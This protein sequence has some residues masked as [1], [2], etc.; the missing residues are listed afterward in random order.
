MRRSGGE[1]RAVRG[2]RRRPRARADRSPPPRA[3][4]R[5]PR[6][7]P[8]DAAATIGLAATL[9]CLLEVSAEK[10]GNVTPTRRFPDAGF[11][12]F[13]RSALAIGPAVGRAAP[14]RVGRTVYEAVAATRRVTRTNT[15]LGIALLLAP[16]AA[17]WRSRGPGGLRRRLARLLRRLDVA[18]ARWAYRAIR[19]ARPGGLGRSPV[20]DVR[21][22]PAVTLR[23]AMRL[24][25]HRDAIAWE[26]AHDFG[27]TLGVGRR[28]LRRAG[29]R[30]LST[31]DAIVQA[32]LEVLGHRP[33]TLIARKAGARAAAAVQARA[34]RVLR[35]GGLHT[36][37]GRAAVRRLDRDL[38]RGGHR[39]NPGAAA[40]LVTA[41]LF[42]SLL[43][44]SGRS[45][46]TAALR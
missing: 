6:R 46:A 5:R 23:E 16:L 25:A 33:D 30:G 12:D 18:D 36:A 40:D 24:A 39:R 37:R 13:A 4:A 1:R 21:R 43:E 38:R 8:A 42:V 22:P 31:L 14:G 10:V 15:N 19:L 28:A 7:S 20:A 27:V 45:R 41:A 34:R 26:Y 44:A 29:R 11:E 2:R 9:A 17:A 3:V 35:A 32:H